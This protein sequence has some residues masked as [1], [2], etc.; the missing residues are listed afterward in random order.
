MGNQW[1][2]KNYCVDLDPEIGE[3]N[4]NAKQNTTTQL[5]Y[6][7]PCMRKRG[8]V[9]KLIQDKFTTKGNLVIKTSVDVSF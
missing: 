5:Q 7:V 8:N 6:T 9:Q 4:E 2:T 3:Q 1:T